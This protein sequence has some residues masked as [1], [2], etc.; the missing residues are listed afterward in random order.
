MCATAESAYKPYVH[1]GAAK[2]AVVQRAMSL[3]KYNKKVTQQN[4]TKSIS[5]LKNQTHV[6]TVQVV[7]TWNHLNILI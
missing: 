5:S 4:T 1:V 6:I 3:Y 2:I 7:F